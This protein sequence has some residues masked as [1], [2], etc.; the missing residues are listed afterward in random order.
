MNKR[1][2]LKLAKLLDHVPPEKFDM[3]TW[4]SMRQA[5][6]T[7][8]RCATKACALGWATAIPEFH[9]AGLRLMADPGDKYATVFFGGESDAD[10]GMEFF[11]L[12]LEEAEYLFFVGAETPHEKAKEIRA[13]VRTGL[14][15]DPA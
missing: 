15:P 4:G 6:G 5:L 8:P 2:L 9:K 1:R 12:S 3:N 7:T 11:D 13:L 14:I 10:A